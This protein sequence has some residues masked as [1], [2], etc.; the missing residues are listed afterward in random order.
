MAM[1]Q[2]TLNKYGFIDANGNQV[3]EVRWDQVNAF[4][5]GFAA[6]KE[7]GLWGFIDKTNTLVIPCQ[8][9]E[10]NAFTSVGDAAP[11]CDVKKPDGTWVVINTEGKD[12]FFG[13]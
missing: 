9:I 12:A 8:Y 11:T 7:N 3:G 10:V 1:V 6:V 2:N 5:Y 4:S 13:P